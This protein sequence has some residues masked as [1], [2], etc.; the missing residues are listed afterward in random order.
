MI[1]TPNT[2]KM[3][4]VSYQLGWFRNRLAIANELQQVQDWWHYID[5]CWLVLTPETATELY[6][7]IAP[8]FQPSDRLLIIEITRN[9]SYQGW[10][11]AEAWAWI[12]A[13]IHRIGSWA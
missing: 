4:V 10:L 5:D 2:L 12:N 6:N 7:R 11:P 9:T 13:N 3:F 8:H 1:R